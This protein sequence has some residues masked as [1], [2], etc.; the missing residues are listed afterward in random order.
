MS[1]QLGHRLAIGERTIGTVPQQQIRRH[2]QIEFPRSKFQREASETKKF[3]DLTID[4][5]A[6]LDGALY[7]RPR[8]RQN[9]VNPST[10]A[11][12]SGVS[13]D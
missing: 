9:A 8:S 13:I 12:F 7:L 10:K 6:S 5:E 3:A 1:T 2:D 11:L 4:D